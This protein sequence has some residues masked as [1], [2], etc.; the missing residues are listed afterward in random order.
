[1]D[2][3][4]RHDSMFRKSYAK[5]K[6]AAV[7]IPPLIA[8]LCFGLSRRT[9][10]S[11]I[12]LNLI[13]LLA[14]SGL[15]AELLTRSIP[16]DI[17]FTDGGIM[18]K[19]GARP[20]QKIPYSE[21]E[22]INCFYMTEKLWGI[23]PVWKDWVLLIDRGKK[24]SKKWFVRSSCAEN[25]D[26]LLERLEKEYLAYC[27]NTYGSFDPYNDKMYFGNR[28]TIQNGKLSLVSLIPCR[29]GSCGH[30]AQ[31]IREKRR[32]TAAWTTG[33]NGNG[34][35][36]IRCI[37]NGFSFSGS[38]STNFQRS[39]QS[40]ESSK[41]S[42]LKMAVKKTITIK[43]TTGLHVRPAGMFCQLAQKFRSD[44]SIIRDDDPS[45]RINGKRILSVLTGKLL[46]GTGI[47]IICDGEDEQEAAQSLYSFIE[48]L[49]E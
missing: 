34:S 1:M 49:R 16:A 37:L 25:F 29:S 10:V 13:C 46:C 35:L 48:N 5:Y 43:N 39:A 6:T 30:S 23:L 11:S 27:K 19:S 20:G 21:L 42:S 3:F 2:E 45:V 4:Y 18:V 12:V 31:K 7:L 28:L 8:L 24:H 44:V 15:A 22:D 47:T 9:E 26:Y 41:E 33:R 36:W 40:A 32:S 17:A 14:A 38:C